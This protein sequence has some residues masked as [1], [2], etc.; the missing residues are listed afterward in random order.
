[1]RFLGRYFSTHGV[2]PGGMLFVWFGL[3]VRRM[4]SLV[5]DLVNTSKMIIKVVY[6]WFYDNCILFLYLV[7]CMWW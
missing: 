3:G 2:A 5:G 4:R 6:V 7:S 1:M